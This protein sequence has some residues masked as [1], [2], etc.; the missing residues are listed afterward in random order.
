M[1]KYLSL[2]LDVPALTSTEEQDWLTYSGKNVQ[3]HFRTTPIQ[4]GISELG[5]RMDPPTFEMRTTFCGFKKRT[6]PFNM[7]VPINLR[8][9]KPSPLPKIL[10]ERTIVDSLGL[11]DANDTT[12]AKIIHTS[13][14]VL[15]PFEGRTVYC[16]RR[17]KGLNEELLSCFLAY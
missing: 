14:R 2:D 9:R 4:R 13:P 6:G 10:A 15:E 16:T 7:R 1:A 11:Q 12:Q 3:E 17:P 8:T 5:A